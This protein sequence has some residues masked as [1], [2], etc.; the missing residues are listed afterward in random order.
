MQK[1][2]NITLTIII[3]LTLSIWDLGYASGASVTVTVDKNEVTLEDFIVLT[4]SVEG[5]SGEPS[6][7]D[8]PAFE[9][10]SRGSSSRIQIVNG[11]MASSV[12]YKYILHPKKEGAF[13]IGPATVNH[14]GKAIHSSTVTITVQ[15][16]RVKAKA[17]QDIFVAA[18]VDNRNP[19]IFEQITYTFRFYR[20]VKVAGAR[21]TG[22]PDF[23]GFIK[24]DLGK[25]KEYQKIING[26]KYI[27][28]EI[29]QAL[30]PAKTGDLE[31]SPSTLQCDV[32]VKRR[33]Q[34]GFFNDPFFDDSFFGFS[35]TEPKILRTSPIKVTVIPLPEK[36]RPPNFS[37]L[38]GDF[39]LVSELSKNRIEVGEST[40]LTLTLTGKG[41]FKTSQSINLEALAYFK[42]YDD[43]PTFEPK[44][45][46]GRIGG[47]LV[48]KKALVPT[49]EGSLKIPGVVVP[50]FDPIQGQYKVTR[51]KPLFIEVIAAQDEEK[52]HLVEAIG[53]ITSKE[54]IKTLGKDILP[55]HSSLKALAAVKTN[56]LSWFNLAFFFLPMLGFI[57]LFLMKQRREK[58]ALDQS[59]FRSKNAYKIFNKKIPS[60]RKLL[61]NP[62]ARFYN[63]ASKMTKDF[64]GDKLNITGSALTPEELEKRLTEAKIKDSTVQELKYI[65]EF[66]E[67]GQFASRKHSLQEKEA[68][69]NAMTSIAKDINKNL[70]V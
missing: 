19:Y 29:K 53:T 60:I 9:V 16:A 11:Q 13:S 10:A 51:A 42:V 23:E 61:R 7:P 33:R 69:I 43:K 48:V 18:E 30:F 24:E 46:S 27:V 63:E 47:K 38:V 25:E 70:R 12:D 4:I 39:Q 37:N 41:N 28:T 14:N 32:V 20:R 26:Q 68:V 8:M 36:D 21:L 56:S 54:A 31:I 64:L 5:A 66:L 17:N 52:L 6:L 15:K 55:I 44:I 50:Y 22:S 57:S 3:L 58:I 65:L 59:F 1:L 34:R 35:K 2:R 45:S 67:E 40:T 49:K 62:D